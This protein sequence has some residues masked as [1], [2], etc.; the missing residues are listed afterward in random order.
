MLK[1]T[2]LLHQ[3][4]YDAQNANPTRTMGWSES[5]YLDGAFGTGGTT[6]A[7]DTY[8]DLRQATL[9]TTAKLVGHRIQEIGVTGKAITVRKVRAGS[10]GS[11][12]DMSFPAVQFT[13]DSQGSSNKRIWLMRGIPDGMIQFGGF[14]P[15][16]SYKR[17]V[18]NFF[19]HVASIWRMKGK[20]L[21]TPK[22]D[23][24]SAT[25]EGGV[26]PVTTFRT[27][28]AHGLVVGNQATI[29]RSTDTAQRQRGQTVLVVTAPTATTFTTNEWKYGSTKGGS[30]RLYVKTPVYPRVNYPLSPISEGI[31]THRDTGRPFFLSRGRR[32]KRTS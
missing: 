12:G 8:A 22:V 16:D 28:A 30:V 2:F 9:P 25:F 32:A 6:T 7:I 20:N 3:S 19:T 5:W 18:E 11:A 4:I 1:V 14:T 24:I 29:L 21:D 13:M 10:Y 17:A 15:A 23:L 31:V 27:A 26:P